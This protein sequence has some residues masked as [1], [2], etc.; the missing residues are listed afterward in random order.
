M[1]YFSVMYQKKLKKDGDEAGEGEE[2][3][4][5]KKGQSGKSKNLN[6]LSEIQY[7]C[8]YVINLLYLKTFL[9]RVMALDEARR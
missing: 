9:L 6:S 3:K 5:K 8:M 4:I 7:Y 2:E 1:N